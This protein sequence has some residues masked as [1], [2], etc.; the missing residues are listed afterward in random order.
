MRRQMR[1]KEDEFRFRLD[2][3]TPHRYARRGS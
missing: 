1:Q 2:T 3:V